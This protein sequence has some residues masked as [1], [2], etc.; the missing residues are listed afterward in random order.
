MVDF[1][2]HFRAEGG[3]FDYS[4]EER[5][6]RDEGYLKIIPRAVKAALDE[7]SIAP[8]DIDHFCLP[9]PLPRVDKLVAKALGIRETSVSDPL[10]AD[11]GETGAAHALLMLTHVL[12]KANP[13]ERI[14]A[15]SF[16]QGA[17]VFVF[18]VTDS[19]A[20]YRKRG[21]GVGKWLEHGSPCSYPR[22]LALSGLVKLDRG[23]RAE[24]DKATALSALYRHRDLVNRLVGGQCRNCGTY[25]V[26][27]LRIC[28]NPD[29]RA[30]DSQQPHS[31]AESHA[32]VV[33][34]SADNLTYTP[35]PPACYGM[36]D[37]DEGGR[38]MV[39]FTNV[40]KGGIEVG[41]PMR[42]VFRVK[43]HDPARGFVRYFWKAAPLAAGQRN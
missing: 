29:C 6:V 20:E 43:D 14:V 23:I 7:A 4:W 19:I 8:A 21:T 1:V 32:R 38:L 42:M 40:H 22:Y 13:G 39:D 31:F 10:A 26:P 9:C 16:G 28:V 36:I 30:V 3:D 25:Q 41:M 12:E 27:R 37:F 11:C 18:Q 17:D 33:S 24:A 2:G 34:W 5:W 35:D 15:C